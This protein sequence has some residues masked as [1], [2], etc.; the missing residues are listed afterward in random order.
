[1]IEMILSTSL[2]AMILAAAY[3][4][5]NAAVSSRKLIEPR[6]EALQTA[7]VALALMTADL[8]CACPLS[9]DYE[10]L[11]THRML[12]EV[13]A[14]NLDFATHNY[15]PRRVHEGDFCEVSYFLDK[16]LESGRLSLWRRRNPTF[17]LDPLSGGSREEIATAVHSLRLEYYDGLD[18]H[19][20]WGDLKGSVKTESSR[21]E[22]A[23][24]SG[25]PEAVRITLRLNSPAR[26]RAHEPSDQNPP[27][28]PLVFQTVAR[29]NLAGSG[30]TAPGGSLSTNAVPG[31]AGQSAPGPGGG[32]GPR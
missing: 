26:S 13:E 16:D 10:F 6:A 18:W 28:P 23:N 22:R 2:M 32:G 31:D 25:M 27:E 4:C 14:D 3:L 29:L 30:Q 1:L 15:T 24:L 21:R 8:R 7:R 12:G 19:D 9:T 20:T 17:A 5:L 11:G